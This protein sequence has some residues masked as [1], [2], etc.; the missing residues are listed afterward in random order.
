MK[1]EE[2][3]SVV[4]LVYDDA[5]RAFVRDVQT[6]FEEDLRGI[7]RMGGENIAGILAAQREVRAYIMARKDRLTYLDNKGLKDAPAIERESGL[8]L[9]AK[10]DMF[11]LFAATIA[12]ANAHNSFQECLDH[13]AKHYNGRSG[14]YVPYVVDEE[15]AEDAGWA[16]CCCSN[17][18]SPYNM[19]RMHDPDTK[20]AALIGCDCALKYTIMTPEEYAIYKATGHKM[21]A[22]YKAKQEAI[23]HK[24]RY[25][26]TMNRFR[27]AAVIKAW[28]SETAKTREAAECAQMAQCDRRWEAVKIVAANPIPMSET[29]DIAEPANVAKTCD[30]CCTPMRPSA[31]TTCFPC[32]QRKRSAKCAGCD[33]AFDSKGGLYAKCY[34]CKSSATCEGCGKPFDGKD[35]QYTK[36]YNCKCTGTC[37]KCGKKFDD[38]GGRY[39]KCYQC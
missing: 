16:K 2:R 4:T 33:K 21:K 27:L 24:A 1:D 18:C 12:D 5:L 26:P 28:R 25:A 8:A 10:P 17:K 11:V 32:N 13:L 29:P 9:R 22:A 35:G 34:T 3:I 14:D 19:T 31:F 36:C 7:Y 39:T 6:E 15:R 20:F 38:K 37:C 30:T 23:A